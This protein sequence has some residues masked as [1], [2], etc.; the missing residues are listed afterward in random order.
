MGRRN[1]RHQGFKDRIEAFILATLENRSDQA[2]EDS[3]G[4]GEGLGG[5]GAAMFYR[6]RDDLVG[7]KPA[8]D[9]LWRSREGSHTGEF[10]GLV[11]SDHGVRLS[12]GDIGYQY[13]T[14]NQIIET[15]SGALSA[16]NCQIPREVLQNEDAPSHQPTNASEYYAR[17][18]RRRESD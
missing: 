18:K 13:S 2:S 9:L 14:I 6:Q 5:G 1:V 10:V 11:G 15:A 3:D 7:L 16:L 8:S 17:D 12:L 4:L